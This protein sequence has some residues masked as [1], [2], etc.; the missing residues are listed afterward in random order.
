MQSADISERTL[1][2]MLLLVTL[3]LLFGQ[4][5]H[6]L[7]T[8]DE[9]REAAIALE[10][11]RNGDWVVPTL[12]GH[13][14]IEKPPL[15]YM[16]ALPF[17]D[18][19]ESWLGVTNSL[20]LAGV[21]WAAGMLLFTGLL[22]YRLLGNRSAAIWS[23]IALG[24]MEGFIINTHWIRTDS[25][26][27][28]FVIFTLWAFSEYYLVSSRWMAILAGIGLAGCFMAKGPIG[29]L[30]VFFGWFPLF[31][32]AARCAAIDKKLPGFIWQHL[33]MLLCF[34]LP[35]AAWIRELIN[36]VD[37]D[38]LWNE[39]FWQNQV[40]RL[41]GTST[42][43]GHIKKGAYLY[44]LLGMAEYTIPWLPF[45]FYWGWQTIKQ[46]RWSRERLFLL[47]WAVGTLLLL[48][49]SSTKRTLYL[50]P[51]LPV[52]AIMLGQ[53]S[54]NWPGWTARYGRG[55]LCFMLLFCVVVIGLPLLGPS[56]PVASHVPA[57]VLQVASK[58]GWRYIPASMLFVIALA[59]LLR[60]KEVHGATHV[61]SSVAIMFLLTFTLVYPLIDAA[62]GVSGKMA[63]LLEGIPLEKRDRIAGW[64]LGETELGLLSA[65]EQMQVMNLDR[66]KVRDVVACRDAR[67]D[68]VLV[69][70]TAGERVKLLEGIPYQLLA[71][72]ALR[73]D[74]GQL[75]TLVA[76]LQCH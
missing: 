54:L 24:T 71:Q 63:R 32:F 64:Q 72:T 35:V 15:F 40:G 66:E 8:P 50:F 62:K 76:G 70:G 43:L 42:E 53:V 68:A 17:L 2:W 37:G 44:Y 58:L 4:F 38:A 22:A 3:V 26:L 23:V 33:L 61:A 45:I 13:S 48:T 74:K 39:W 1:C 31:F 65:Y 69:N 47:C 20:R 9:P 52:F 19:F 46:R 73:S 51:L 56:L 67:F 25:A 55:W 12:G 36:H 49:L 29:P 57:D 59:L 11:Y 18:G 30:T 60:R 7:W 10:M 27:A 14:F 21:V 28:F 75:L 6:Q 16:A 41:T 34:I 5:D